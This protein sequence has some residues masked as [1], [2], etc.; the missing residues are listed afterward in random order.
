MRD[1]RNTGTMVGGPPGEGISSIDIII[2]IIIIM[3][4]IIVIVIYHCKS[5]ET[6][7]IRRPPQSEGIR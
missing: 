3:T 6:K 7:A 1:S 4:I 5:S 2:I